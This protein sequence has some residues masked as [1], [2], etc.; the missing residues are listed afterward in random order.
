MGKNGSD[1]LLG[2][3]GYNTYFTDGKDT[4]RDDDGKGQVYFN[5]LKLTDG[6]QIEKGS[7]I[8]KTKDNI[9]Y[10]L[11]GNKLIVNDSL[12]IED[13][14]P[15]KEW[16]DIN[17]LQADEI[18]VNVSNATAKEKKQSMSFDIN[19]SRDLKENEF[20]KVG[21]N[22]KEYVFIHHSNPNY[23]FANLN[24]LVA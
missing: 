3:N 4:I 10:E 8:Y 17:L 7:N 19:L 13:F 6:T 9:K 22:G 24:L 5:G 21:I 12:V 15:Y 11:Q 16:L 1:I 2:G 14:N 18:A 23:E 20:V